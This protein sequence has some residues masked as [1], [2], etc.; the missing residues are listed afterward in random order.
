LVRASK[1]A[2]LEKRRYENLSPDQFESLFLQI[3]NEHM[4]LEDEEEG[5]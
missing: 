2:I 3:Q 1:E 5:Y 4:L